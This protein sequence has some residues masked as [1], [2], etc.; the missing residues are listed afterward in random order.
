MKNDLTLTIALVALV[1]CCSGSGLGQQ[2]SVTPSVV[3][4]EE[5]G[6]REQDGLEGPVR[7]VRVETAKMMVKGGKIVEGPRAIRGI[8]TYDSMGKKIDSVDYPVESSTVPGKE[9][10]RYDD[11]GNIVEMVVLGTDNSILSKEAYEYEFDPI[12]NWTKMSTSVAVYE[13][14]KVTFEPTE[15]TYRTISYYYNQA[16]EKLGNAT[17]KSKPAS[18]PSAPAVV[19]DNTKAPA[20]AIAANHPVADK[21]AADAKKTV[22]DPAPAPATPATLTKVSENK[23]TEVAEKKETPVEP[24]S[25]PKPTVIKLEENALRA[26][27]L[28]LPQPE[29]PKA[30]L[31]AR[32]SGKVEVQLLVNEKGLVTNARA[33]GG[34]PMLT[35]AAENAALK[36]RFSPA[37]LSAEPGITFGVITYS[38]VPPEAPS[39]SLASNTVTAS[40][41][42]VSEERKIVPTEKSVPATTRPATLTESKPKVNAPESNYEKGMTFLSAGHYEEA[43]TLFNQV[44]QADPNDANA[45]TKLGIAYSGMNRDKEALAGF[46]MAAQIKRSVIDASGYFYWGKSY[47]ALEKTSDAISSFKQAL[48]MM[49]AEAIGLEPSKADMPTLEQIHH[50]LGTAYINS[51]R[52]ND[53]I[54]AFKQV[55]AINPANAE[56]HYALAVAYFANGDRKAAEE[57]NKILATLDLEMSQKLAAVLNGG[58]SHLGCRNIACR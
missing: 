24:A 42:T 34:N 53:S 44:V 2:G 7:R 19:T 38:F 16:I 49:R 12:G 8:A 52:F 37:K 23:A 26:A 5:R 15:V 14:G 13:N 21:V 33:Q 29:Y 48:S 4:A 18:V 30:A 3:T 32:A 39:P 56:A 51:R 6:T 22:T 50:Y 54:K 36:A 41:P 58:S 40:K 47:L 55:V 9:R 17:A 10:Y 25:P 57:Q 43:A 35:Q 28:D 46:K 11:K 45:Y 31:M 1:I 27:A 20:K